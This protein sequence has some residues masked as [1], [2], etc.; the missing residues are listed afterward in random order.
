MWAGLCRSERPRRAAVVNYFADGVRSDTDEAVL[1]G[2]PVIK[3][4]RTK[5][6]DNHVKY[7]FIAST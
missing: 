7:K 2:V 5:S 6:N 1:N 3:K 4:V